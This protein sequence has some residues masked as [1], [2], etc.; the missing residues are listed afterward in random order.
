MRA[1]C[2][3]HGER[4]PFQLQSNSIDREFGIA[5]LPSGAVQLAIVP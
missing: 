1:S 5:Q 2:S 3:I 4:S